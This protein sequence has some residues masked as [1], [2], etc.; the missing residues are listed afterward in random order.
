MVEAYLLRIIQNQ[1][2]PA[3]R[4][5]FLV[6]SVDLFLRHARLYQFVWM[7]SDGFRAD[8]SLDPNIMVSKIKRA[9]RQRSTDSASEASEAK[10]NTA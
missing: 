9:P 2:R 8:S 6:D 5:R 4:L 3:D 1:P 10:P 7:D